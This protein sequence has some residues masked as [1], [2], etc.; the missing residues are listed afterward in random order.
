M[1]IGLKIHRP[2]EPKLQQRCV[3]FF[4][5]LKASI[6]IPNCYSSSKYFLYPEHFIKTWPYL[7]QLNNTRNKPIFWQNYIY[8]PIA[9]RETPHQRKS[10]TF[11]DSQASKISLW[12]PR[13][14]IGGRDREFGMDMYT[15]LYLKQ[16][17]NKVLLYSTWNSTQCYV[18]AWVGGRLGENGYMYMYGWVPLLF[19]QNY[20]NSVN[21]L[22]PKTN[23][24]V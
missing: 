1:R 14:R 16:I 6:K 12:L 7:S 21:Q 17:T 3:L 20:H 8:Q 24:K 2:Q 22:Y 18:A 11:T 9:M 15:L 4:L 13:G 19:T 5:Y 10:E 23:L